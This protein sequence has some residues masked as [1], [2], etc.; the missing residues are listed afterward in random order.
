[1]LLTILST[2]RYKGGRA[3]ERVTIG[4]LDLP[5]DRDLIARRI[6]ELDVVYTPYLSKDG[7][8]GS[9]DSLIFAGLFLGANHG[10]SDAIVVATARARG[11]EGDVSERTKTFQL[12]HEV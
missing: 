8:F 5:R 6:C 11:G 1:M 12:L 2:K 4:V 9:G 3:D 10:T 7:T